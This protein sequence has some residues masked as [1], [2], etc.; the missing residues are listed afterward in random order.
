[1]IYAVELQM[2]GGKHVGVNSS[3]LKVLENTSSQEIVVICDEKHAE[4]LKKNYTYNNLTWNTFLFSGDKELRKLFIPFKVM[5]E[6]VLAIKIF[7]SAK[8]TKSEY[9]FFFSSFPFTQIFLNLFSILFK[10]RIILCQH[11]E[12]GVLSMRKPKLLSKIFGYVQKIFFKFRGKYTTVLFYG[13]PIK[14]S[15]FK[16]FPHYRKENVIVVDHPY[17]FNSKSILNSSEKKL[18]IVISGIGTG[19]MN[20]NSHLIYELAQSFEKEIKHGLIQFRH[21]GN[22]SDEVLSYKNDLVENIG[23]QEFMERD[24][25]E[26]E[27]RKA[28]IF[29]YFFKKDTLYDLCPSGTFFDAIKYQKPILA[30]ENP[31][32]EYYINK[33][34][35]IGWLFQDIL[36]M[37]DFVNANIIRNNNLEDLLF[38]VSQNLEKSRDILSLEQ[39]AKQFAAQADQ[40]EKNS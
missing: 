1:M 9:I 37:R 14:N 18:P 39:I 23:N 26:E 4:L 2:Q 11:G 34:G 28:D 32:F 36:K 16:L 22:I 8:K 29:V 3:M 20:K 19:L 13:E 31:F 25:F 38:E 27:I 30:L 17:N 40:Y 33:L 15:F 5:R 12:L 35:E 10:Q 7:Y 24:A 6:V 21:I